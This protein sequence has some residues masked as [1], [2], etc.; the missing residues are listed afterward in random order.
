MFRQVASDIWTNY[1]RKLRFS[2]RSRGL[3]RPGRASEPVLVAGFFMRTRCYRA[4]DRSRRHDDRR[5]SLTTS[6][7]GLR[8]AQRIQG[9]LE[10][11][12]FFK[13]E[14]HQVKP[15]HEV[16]DPFDNSVGFEGDVIRR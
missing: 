16:H 5:L 9:R 8:A 14:K 13:R 15:A 6:G 12:L 3:A 2:R 10:H 1:G 4:T 11:R 7:T